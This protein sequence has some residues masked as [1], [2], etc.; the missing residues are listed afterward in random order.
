[1][2]AAAIA[3]GLQSRSH[4]QM[5]AIVATWYRS[6]RS[7]QTFRLRVDFAHRLERGHR[8]GLGAHLHADRVAIAD[9]V[10]RLQHERDS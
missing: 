7:T 1:M 9:V 5:T 4:G 10:D 3:R 8:V 2:P 6:R